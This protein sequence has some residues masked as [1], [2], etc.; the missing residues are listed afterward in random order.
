[1]R[2]VLT[3]PVPG[4]LDS[5]ELRKALEGSTWLPTA[6]PDTPWTQS[7]IGSIIDE[8]PEGIRHQLLESEHV[9]VE[10]GL[11]V[12]GLASLE[13]RNTVMIRLVDSAGD[14]AAIKSAVESVAQYLPEALSN[15]TGNTN[16]ALHKEIEIRQ[17]NGDIT[18]AKGE[19]V[20]PHIL[21]FW[22]YLSAERRRELVLSRW[23][24][25]LLLAAF[26]ASVALEWLHPIPLSWP[27]VTRGHVERL[28]SALAVAI[29]TM[30]VNLRFEYRD[31]R[32]ETTDV[33]WLFG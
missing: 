4:Q 9:Y 3:L 26:V 5:V 22:R 25:L 16:L 24:G 7:R 31:W 1:M 20:T 8:F 23:L 13:R 18:V 10:V 19:I 21:G 6:A 32:S 15:T 30:L 12:K 11:T 29:L 17:K 33:R 28:S 2:A 14:I 27:D